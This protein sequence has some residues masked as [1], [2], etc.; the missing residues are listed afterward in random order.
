M[1]VQCCPLSGN[2]DGETCAASTRSVRAAR[3][4]HDCC[5][6]DDGIKPGDKYEHYSGIWDRRPDSFKTCLSCVEIRD[7]FACNGWMFGCLWEDLAQNF[8]P[9][10]KA[11]GPCM[12]GLSPGAKARLFARRLEWLEARR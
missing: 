4:E 2:Y 10:M 7:H 8:F 12:E 11:G 3:K 9:T 5:E 6:C 1:S